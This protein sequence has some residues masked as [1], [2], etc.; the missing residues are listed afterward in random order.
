MI[1][2]PVRKAARLPR[3]DGARS[4]RPP[5]KEEEHEVP[6]EEPNEP[7]ED[8]QEHFDRIN[9]FCFMQNYYV[10]SGFPGLFLTHQTQTWEAAQCLRGRSSG[11]AS[12]PHY[13]RYHHLVFQ[14]PIQIGRLIP[15]PTTQQQDPQ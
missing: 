4:S 15:P 1:D 3:S 14:S 10:Q 8:F 12:A 7:D 11:P 5:R 9:M 13:D 6:I 2:Q